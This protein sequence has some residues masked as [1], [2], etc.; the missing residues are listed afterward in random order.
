MCVQ[1]HILQVPMFM[2]TLCPARTLPLP[3]RD[4]KLLGKD[5]QAIVATKQSPK[6]R[7]IQHPVELRVLPQHRRPVGGV[8]TR[9]HGRCLLAG[10]NGIRVSPRRHWMFGI[11]SSD[12]R[13]PHLASWPDRGLPSLTCSYS[14]FRRQQL[15]QVAP[16]IHSPAQHQM[17]GSLQPAHRHRET[18]QGDS[19]NSEAAA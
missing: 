6:A 4:S 8:A 11:A 19:P 18:Q 1:Y 16:F 3:T 10:A 13:P 15:F 9:R 14:S 12:T 5:K 2:A 17:I 7:P